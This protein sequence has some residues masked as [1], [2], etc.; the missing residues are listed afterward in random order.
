[1]GAVEAGRCD[2]VDGALAGFDARDDRDEA[3]LLVD[4]FRAMVSALQRNRSALA[5]H[6]GK[7]LASEVS[8]G[9][10]GSGRRVR[11]TALFLDVEGF[12]SRVSRDAPEEVVGFLQEVVAA[13]VDVIEAHDGHVAALFGDTLL[14][15]WGLVDPH[16]DDPARAVT[17]ATALHER[18]RAISEAR[19]ARGEEPFTVGIGVATGDAV[20]ATVGQAARA[21][22]VVVGE[23]VALARRIEEEA[24]ATGFGVLVAE[25][26]F[27][28]V[29]SIYE[30]APTPPVLF[31]GFGVPVTLYR[32]RPKKQRAVQS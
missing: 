12:T 23:P 24:K 11:V 8:A 22:S 13:C 20:L 27:R 15:V 4:G 3:A 30:G 18:C 31:R 5:R 26:T 21:E 1:M 14:A 19:R 9:A 6:V 17:A 7:K 25:E 29:S 10:V 2:D 16:D 32:V 28:A